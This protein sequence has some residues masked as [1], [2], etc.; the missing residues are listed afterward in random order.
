M[1]GGARHPELVERSDAELG[2]LVAEE[3][4]PLLGLAG[5]PE[6]SVV[7]RYPETLPRY[8]L[9]QPARRAALARALPRG[10]HV[11]GNYCNGVGLTALI[12]NAR[13]LARSHAG[14]GERAPSA[15]A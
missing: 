1:L 13:A 9:E 3:V 7:L 15:S 4:G 14:S 2:D 8:D 5:A 10:L 12:P 11:L 6:W